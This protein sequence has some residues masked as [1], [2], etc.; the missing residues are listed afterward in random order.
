M[1]PFHKIQAGTMCSVWGL[2]SYKG[3]EIVESFIFSGSYRMLELSKPGARLCSVC[4][5]TGRGVSQGWEGTARALPA[6]LLPTQLSQES[7]FLT[8]F[9]KQRF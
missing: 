7:R 2:A 1:F 5:Q 6:V 9:R 8:C 3:V 4:V